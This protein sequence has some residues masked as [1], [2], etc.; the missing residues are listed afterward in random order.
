MVSLFHWIPQT[1][2]GLSASLVIRVVSSGWKQQDRAQLGVSFRMQRLYLNE[3]LRHCILHT[4]KKLIC[5]CKT[6]TK[7]EA[8]LAVCSTASIQ[9]QWHSSTLG[10]MVEL[11]P[12]TLRKLCQIELHVALWLH[13]VRA[14]ATCDSVRRSRLPDGENPVPFRPLMR[15]NSRKTPA[16][17][18]LKRALPTKRCGYT[19]I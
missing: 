13:S 17:A 4:H 9:S 16:D 5:E 7:Q 1:I 18:T 6:H 10:A 3:K 14:F 11:Q 12:S 8:C 2:A 19:L 15:Q